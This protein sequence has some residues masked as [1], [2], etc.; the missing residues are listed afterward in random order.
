ML[1]RRALILGCT[2]G[3]CF[4]SPAFAGEFWDDQEPERWAE[5]DVQ[6][7]LTK[8]PWAKQASV[9]MGG[10]GPGGMGGMGGPG[11]G[12]PP[13]M[14]M[15]GPG[16]RGGPGGMN[17]VVRWES[18][19]PIRHARKTKIPDSAPGSYVISVSGLTI[20]SEFGA[21]L[22]SAAFEAMK[23]ATFLQCN[24]K[25]LIA[26]GRISTSFDESGVLFY[27]FPGD[28]PI[29]ADDK[30]VVFQTKSDLFSIKVRFTPKEMRYR[31][32]LAI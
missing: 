15:G 31:G 4:V 1:T 18:A 5:K 16:G 14:D 28:D 6:R 30:Q 7:L 3:P 32:K 11:M 8:S 21:S 19:A 25:K 2:L 13:G 24:G 9:E 29:S 27:E 22:D 23:K 20:L 10:G 26:P 17:A 12:G